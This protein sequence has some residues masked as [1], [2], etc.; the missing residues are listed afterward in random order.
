[1][2]AIYTYLHKPSNCAAPQVICRATNKQLE[3]AQ[4]GTTGQTSCQPQNESILGAV[5]SQGNAL[6][7]LLAK[8]VPQSNHFIDTASSQP[9]GPSKLELPPKEPMPAELPLEMDAGDASTVHQE[10]GLVCEFPSSKTNLGFIFND[11]LHAQHLYI[12]LF[13]QD[14][15]KEA[16]QL[17]QFEKEAFTS[18]AKAKAK[19]AAKGKAKAKPKSK[20]KAKPVAKSQQKLTKPHPCSKPKYGYYGKPP[21]KGPFGCLRCRG[22]IKGCSQCLQPSYNGLRFSS[23]Q[24]WCQWEQARKAQG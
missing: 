17:D 7:Q 5:I 19:A 20:A 6:N 14:S 10:A 13:G 15:Q 8:F 24:Q 9:A 23:R 3:D 4:A 18:L 22:N 11:I 21:T 16:S 2:H 1:M 12:L